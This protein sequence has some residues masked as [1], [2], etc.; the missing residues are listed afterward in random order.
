MLNLNHYKITDLFVAF[1][2]I[3]IIF[4]LSFLGLGR[5]GTSV[6]IPLG[7]LYLFLNKF[8]TLKYILGLKA[9]KWYLFFFIFTSISILYANDSGAAI[10]TQGKTFIVFMFSLL[11][12][13]YAINFLRNVY[14]FY[15]V[16]CLVLLFIAIIVLKTGVSIGDGDRADDVGL[17]ANTYGYYIY[18]GLFS[19]FILYTKLGLKKKNRRLLFILIIVASICSFWLVLISASRGASIITS[20]LVIGN[21]FIISSIS[22][23]GVFKKLFF[24]I[25]TSF[26]LIYTISYLNDN[27]LQNSYLLKRFDQME[28]V[29]NPREFLASNAIEV[30][31]RNPIIGVGA[32]NY[33]LIPKRIEQ[34]SFSHNTFTEIFANFGSIGLFLFGG[35]FLTVLFKL[36]RLLRFKNENTKIVLYQILLFLI[37]F[38]VYSTLYVVYLSNVFMHLLFVIYAHLS[39]LDR[40]LLVKNKI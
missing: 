21:V 35:F 40:N 31:L 28:E 18:N 14:F 19:L 37:L 13:A 9:I 1:Y 23:K 22:K 24:L 30:G 8:K 32:G 2:V 4:M 3:A 33:A 11:V 34:G 12:F 16:N 6:L 27:Y 17:N 5:L 15:V 29:E 39:I 10:K 38:L 36:R 26:F 20:L 25:L 7:F